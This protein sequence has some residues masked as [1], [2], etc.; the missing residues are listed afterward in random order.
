MTDRFGRRSFL[1]RVAVPGVV[2]GLAPSIARASTPEA[3]FVPAQNGSDAQVFAE[4]RKHF[5]FPTD[6][7]YCNTGTLGASPREVVDALANGMRR[8]R[9]ELPDWP[10][11]QPT[12]SRS[13]ATSRCIA[14]RDSG[15]AR[16][17]T[18]PATRSP[19]RRTR[20][21]G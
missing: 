10:Y 3:R 2:A 16:S 12:A 5:L 7:T 15:R 21:W 20:R 4:A 6:V 1:T 14:M 17:S 13:R 19:S 9:A 18:R 11:F 8:S